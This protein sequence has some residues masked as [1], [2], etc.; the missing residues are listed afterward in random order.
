MEDSRLRFT[1][2]QKEF[3]DLRKDHNQLIQSSQPS[4]ERYA[5]VNVEADRITNSLNTLREQILLWTRSAQTSQTT[6]RAEAA[7]AAN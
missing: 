3:P 6:V 7:P 4:A 2:S 1:G 5:L